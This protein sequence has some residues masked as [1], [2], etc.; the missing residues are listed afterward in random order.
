MKELYTAPEL[1]LLCLAPQERLAAELD[2][3]SLLA[4]TGG[5]VSADPEIDI[6]VPIIP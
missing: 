2:F 1:E 6:D 3:D 4:G 5:G